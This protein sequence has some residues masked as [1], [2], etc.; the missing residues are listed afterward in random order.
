MLRICLWSLPRTVSTA[1]LR[2]FVQRSD[3]EGVDEPLYASYLLRTGLQHPL[4]EEILASQSGDWRAVLAHVLLAPQAKPV[5][6]VKHMA[7][8]VPEEADGEL[9]GIPHAAHVFLV[10]DPREQLPSLA[11][12]IGLPEPEQTGYGQQ[13]RLYRKLVE[14]GEKE[15]L[16][17]DS[18]DLLRDPEGT[19]RTLC[20][21]LGLRFEAA[22]LHWE[23]GRHPAF[24]V[25][26]PEW[27]RNVEASTSFRPHRARTEPFPEALQ[28][29]LEW[30]RPLYREMTDHPG[31]IR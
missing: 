27:Y 5:Q 22:M 21:R 17:L 7:H 20:T 4:R 26:A 12:R 6:F 30:A 19:L 1:L 25:W 9:L 3:T 18:G 10:R 13:A 31:R 29:L 8:H 16:V 14:M 11:Q 23:A 2:S 24:G 28:P 15:P